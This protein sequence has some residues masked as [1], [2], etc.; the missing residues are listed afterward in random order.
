MDNN[1]LSVLA[2]TH[3]PLCLWEGLIDGCHKLG[4]CMLGGG[5]GWICVANNPWAFWL[6]DLFQIQIFIALVLL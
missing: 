5:G 3:T 6:K 1:N 2:G 4:G